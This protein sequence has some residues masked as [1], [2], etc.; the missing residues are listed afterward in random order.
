MFLFQ[1][2]IKNDDHFYGE[3]KSPKKFTVIKWEGLKKWIFVLFC[4]LTRKVKK[5][6]SGAKASGAY[7]LQE[8]NITSLRHEKISF[9][10]KTAV[11]YSKQFTIVSG[12]FLMKLTLIALNG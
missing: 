6:F 1:W 3:K 5:L 8:Q 2:T 11:F 7:G 10:R 12:T 9:M 4:F